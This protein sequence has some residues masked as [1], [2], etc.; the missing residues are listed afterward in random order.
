MEAGVGV[1]K[2]ALSYADCEEAE[3]SAAKVLVPIVKSE[4][5]K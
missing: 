4:S 2:V 1:A 5:I 3:I